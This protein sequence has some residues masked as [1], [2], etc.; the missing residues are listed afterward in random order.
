MALAA[1]KSASFI[2]DD[3]DGKPV[4]LARNAWHL[5]NAVEQWPEIRFLDTLESAS[6]QAAA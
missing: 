2:A 3:H 5:D 1:V 6:E 4:F